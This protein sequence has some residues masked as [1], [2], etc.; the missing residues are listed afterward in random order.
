[1]IHVNPT[2]V[3]HL[4][5]NYHTTVPHTVEALSL[6]CTHWLEHRAS[7]VTSLNFATLWEDIFI[8]GLGFWILDTRLY[9]CQLLGAK[10]EALTLPQGLCFKWQE[11]R[12]N[13]VDKERT[14]VSGDSHTGLHLPP[15]ICTKNFHSTRMVYTIR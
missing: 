13:S 11:K 12:L 10:V 3:N 6:M 5:G 1:M 4:C 15:Y 14:F 7:S 8:W 2:C 9:L